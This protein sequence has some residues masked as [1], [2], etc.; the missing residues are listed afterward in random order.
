M[1]ARRNI[2]QKRPPGPT[3]VSA[4]GVRSD[5]GT[6]VGLTEQD[7]KKP[8]RFEITEG[9]R[10]SVVKWIGDELIVGSEYLWPGR[11]HERLHIST[12]QYARI[13]HDG[14]HVHSHK[15]RITNHWLRRISP[16]VSS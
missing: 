8:V 9:T 2:G 12:R 15:S 7:S 5:Q 6:D 11:F 3:H 1:P 4:I 13:H 10:A 14:Q 16:I